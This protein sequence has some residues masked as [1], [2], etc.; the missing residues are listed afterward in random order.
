MTRNSLAFGVALAAL[1]FAGLAGAT[2]AG[3]PG[4]SS[5]K[6]TIGSSGP[7]S[8]EAA[9]AAGVLRGADAYFKYVNAR[10]G[11]YGRSIDFKYLDDSYDPSQTVQ[12]VRQLI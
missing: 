8:G 3:T 4:V 1:S 7:L 9:A 2:G 6:I 12:N 11:V 10:G 5:T